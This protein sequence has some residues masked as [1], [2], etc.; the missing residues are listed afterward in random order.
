MEAMEK[1]TEN[2]VAGCSDNQTFSIRQRVAAFLAGIPE[3]AAQSAALQ[4]LKTKITLDRSFAFFMGA[5][6]MVVVEELF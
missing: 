6:A 5:L 4:L 2:Q 1:L 3:P